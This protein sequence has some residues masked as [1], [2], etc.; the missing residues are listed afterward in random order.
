MRKTMVYLAGPYSHPDP[1]VRDYRYIQHLKAYTKLLEQGF[2][3]IAP[4]VQGH[5]AVGYSTALDLW[6]HKEWLDLDFNYIERCD[7]VYILQIEGWKESKGVNA[8]I[9]FCREN[10]IPIVYSENMP[11]S[12]LDL[13]LNKPI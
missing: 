11:C 9:A 1:K 8:E 10:D 2:A 4:I 3:V 7:I 6:L 5:N 13:D 12:K